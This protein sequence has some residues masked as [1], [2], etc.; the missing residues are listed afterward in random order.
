MSSVGA[1]PR[2]LRGLLEPLVAQLSSRDPVGGDVARLH[3]RGRSEPCPCDRCSAVWMPWVSGRW[4][5]QAACVQAQSVDA[6]TYHYWS[7][8]RMR[9][10]WRYTEV[11]LAA[12]F[13][14]AQAVCE[15]CVL[16]DECLTDAVEN[17]RFGLVRGGRH[18]REIA[19]R[20]RT[21][22]RQGG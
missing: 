10:R 4:F 5:E 15:T 11:E 18:P 8:D 9:L 14:H 7:P 22:D 2:R 1:R 3:P 12:A 17:R 21:R 13:A 19:M 6:P 20:I 16:R